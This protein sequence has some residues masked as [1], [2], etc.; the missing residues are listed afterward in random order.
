MIFDP[1]KLT[2]P[3]RKAA[4]ARDRRI[5]GTELRIPRNK[6]IKITIVIV[7]APGRAG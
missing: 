3:C 1:A 2:K 7:V 4:W 6:E 5:I